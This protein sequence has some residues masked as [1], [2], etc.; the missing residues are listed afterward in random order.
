MPD[1]RQ[2]GLKIAISVI[3]REFNATRL[4]VRTGTTL[5]FGGAVVAGTPRIGNAFGKRGAG[6]ARGR[7]PKGVKTGQRGIG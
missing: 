6:S 4:S 3:K 1:P 2:P 7:D 5:P